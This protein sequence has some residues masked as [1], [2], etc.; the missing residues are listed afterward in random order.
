MTLAPAEACLDSTQPPPRCRSHLVGGPG[1]AGA[2]GRQPSGAV[3]CSVDH[4]DRAR[5]E[6]QVEQS[7]QP[8]GATRA[9]WVS[10]P[11]R[12]DPE[13]GTGEGS[14]SQHC[15]PGNCSNRL[16]TWDS[17]HVRILVVEDDHRVARGM[18]AA[19]TRAGHDVLRVATVAQALE[20]PAADIVLLD[21]GLPDGDG[22]TVCRHL[23]RL[24]S[25]GVIMVTARGEEADRVRGLR[26]GADDYVVKPFGV[27]ELLA[28]VEAVAR[29]TRRARTEG[30]ALGHRQVG[31]LELDLDAR[32]ARVATAELD[33]TPKEFELLEYLSA[34]P[35]RVRSRSRDRRASL[36]VLLRGPFP[37]P[38]RP[39]R[40]V[41][42]QARR[43]RLCSDHLHHPRG[44]LP[45]LPA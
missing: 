13:Q 41:A 31:D 45:A 3:G 15:R 16:V 14:P 28:R 27:A 5:S 38:R 12:S 9:S 7:G 42:G 26:G 22:L 35:G 36:A 4:R 2:R 29:R 17:D 23:R 24:S 10:R 33:L 25:A 30:D 20:A 40:L 19:L 6:R 39:H 8:V 11:H 37:N 21:L 44:G 32:R 43:F 34:T 18:V 1:P